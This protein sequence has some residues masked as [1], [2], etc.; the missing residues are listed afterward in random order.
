MYRQ[1]Q[2]HLL[3]HWD[4]ALLDSLMFAVASVISLYIRLGSFSF[5]SDRYYLGKMVETMVL[6]VVVG[7]MLKSYKSVL[8]RGYFVELGMTVQHVLLT[9]ACL[10]S[11]SYF[12]KN[13]AQLSR[14]A[15]G[16][17]MLI[18]VVLIYIFRNLL[19]C[20][21]K[22]LPVKPVDRKVLVVGT[23]EDVRFIKTKLKES[24]RLEFQVIAGA[25][26]EGDEVVD[27]DVPTVLYSLAETILFLENNVV[28]EVLFLS[29]S[30]VS[31][32]KD[33]KKSCDVS[34]LITHTY[35]Q[36]E[37]STTREQ[38]VE[39]L[40]GLSV[41][42]SCIKIVSPNALLIKR[43]TDVLA[44]IVGLVITAFLTIILGP[45][46]Y[47]A[48]PGPIFFSQIRLGENGRP[49][50]FYKFRSMYLDAEERKSSLMQKNEMQ[51]L[52]FKVEHDPRILGSGEDGTK[53]GI[54]WFIR[55]TSLDEFPQFWNILKGDMSLVGTRPPTVDEW[56][57]YELHHRSRLR[58]KPGLTG[59]WQASGR[60]SITN[61]EEVVALDNQYIE[62]WSLSLDIKII[63][64]TMFNVLFRKG[65]K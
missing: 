63:I 6:S 45:F 52:M 19:K 13:S 62:H 55:T 54:G 12:P 7:A 49:F 42:S 65:A 2:L 34:G 48:D 16:Y 32:A 30:S 4:F 47:L 50:K 59:M 21:L 41:L 27:K 35:I 58:V 22:N 46:I 40:G 33:L 64:R 26:N 37:D 56:E 11:L 8:V 1:R 25:T 18:A 3:K 38:V 39:K 5:L 53:K 44:G 61:F 57:K 29:M 20:R 10:L 9:G 23:S 17:M 60:S 43:V 51:G 24:W 14:L 31:Y 36:G 15:F 28:D